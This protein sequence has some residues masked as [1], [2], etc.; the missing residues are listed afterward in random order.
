MAK[1]APY[2]KVWRIADPRP[3]I[4]ARRIIISRAIDDNASRGNHRSHVTGSIARIDRP[5]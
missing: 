4:D 5:G 3:A 2:R 1:D